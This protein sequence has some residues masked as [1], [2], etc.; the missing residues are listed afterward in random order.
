MPK[1]LVSSKRLMFFYK[2]RLCPMRLIYITTV[3]NLL[4]YK[5]SRAFIEAPYFSKFET[6]YLSLFI[7][8]EVVFTL[9]IEQSFHKSSIFFKI[10]NNFFI[11][12]MALFGFSTS[13]AHCCAVADS[14][15]CSILESLFILLEVVF[16]LQLE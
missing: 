12:F 2:L 1:C 5:W 9:K 6:F 13:K 4:P 15:L 14:N 16:T 11:R 10:W 8:L 3:E 7:L